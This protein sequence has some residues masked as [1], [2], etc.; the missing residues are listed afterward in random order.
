[1]VEIMF[2]EDVEDDLKM[3]FNLLRNSI[4]FIKEKFRNLTLFEIH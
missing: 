2:I 3:W 4:I 1:M